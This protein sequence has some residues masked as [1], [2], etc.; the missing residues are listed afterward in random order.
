MMYLGKVI[1]SRVQQAYRYIKYEVFKGNP[2][3]MQAVQ[4]F[5]FEGNPVK[6]MIALVAETGVKGETKVIGYINKNVLADTG[7]TRVYSTDADGEL[8]AYIWCKN[9]GTL[10]L[11]GDAD[12]AVR[13][14]KLE[15][16]YNQLK[17]DHDALV[18]KVTEFLTHYK[19][20]THPVSG[21]VAGATTPPVTITDPQHSTGDISDAKIDEIKT[22]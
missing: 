12:N 18:D 10:L 11:N 3:E 13:Y 7:E 14:S 20:H 17:D 9:D 4:P 2:E 8:K 22:P 15:E 1:S 19:A 5:G 6:D 16:A 21:A